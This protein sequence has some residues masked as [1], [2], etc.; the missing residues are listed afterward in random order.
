[1]VYE[2]AATS[3]VP[4]ELIAAV[5]HVENRGFIGDQAASSRVSGNGAIGPMQLMPRTAWQVLQVDPWDPRQNIHGGARYLSALI[6]R[7]HGDVRL[8]LVAYN[9][10]PTRVQAGEAPRSALRYAHTVLQLAM[11]PTSRPQNSELLI[12]HSRPQR[13]AD[14]AYLQ[15]MECVR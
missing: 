13:P 7:F 2:A 14:Y 12:E 15:P 10:G 6:R 1:M 11:R 9:A 3:H 8:A 4:A 5:L